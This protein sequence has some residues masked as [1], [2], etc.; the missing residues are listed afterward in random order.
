MLDI[1]S[2]ICQIRCDRAMDRMLAEASAGGTAD[3]LAA[4]SAAADRLG[5]MAL[6]RVAVGC[7]AVDREG[8]MFVVADKKLVASRRVPEVPRGYHCELSIR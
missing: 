1:L 7:R 4:A 3:S 2:E 8:R 6:A 5:N